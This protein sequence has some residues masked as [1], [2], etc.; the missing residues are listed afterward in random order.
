MK[1]PTYT[2]LLGMLIS[3][4]TM[5]TSMKYPYKLRSRVLHIPGRFLVCILQGIKFSSL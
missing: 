4:V 2:W 5:E 1:N 3:P